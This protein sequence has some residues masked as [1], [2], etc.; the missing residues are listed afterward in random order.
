[1]KLT[2][3]ITAH[4]ARFLLESLMSIASQTSKNFDL[5]CCADTSKG[6]DALNCF[7]KNLQYINCNSKRIIEVLGNDTAGKVRNIGF[8]EAKTEWIGYLDG[9]DLLHFNTVSFINEEILANK[10]VSENIRIFSSGMVR[11][12]TD[13]LLENIEESLT[14]LPPLQI[15]EIDPDTVNQPTYFNQF[16]IIRKNDWKEYPF[17]E[18]TNGEDID[19]ML[20]HL[21]KGKFKKIPQ[22]LYFYRFTPNSFSE[23]KYPQ[24]DICTQRYQTKYYKNYYDKNYNSKFECNF[25]NIS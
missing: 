13:G 23:K 2:I 4:H 17:N 12:H 18:T 1:M 14:Y 9:D 5:I 19:Y 10:S 7:K 21:L 11:I 20:H 24:G 15:Y 25:K 3:V 16:Q 6:K 8:E 22:Y